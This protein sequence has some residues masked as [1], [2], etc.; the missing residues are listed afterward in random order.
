MFIVR[1]Q[2]F[3]T[4]ANPKSKFPRQFWLGLSLAF[5]VFY[6]WQVLQQAFSSEYV[7]SDDA[8]QHV[9]WMQRFLDPQLFPNDL[10]ADYFQ[11]VAPIGFSTFY[12]FF[13][14]LGIEPLLLSKILPIV[15]GIVATGYC[16][17]LCLEIFP[18]PA[19]GFIASLLFQQNLWMWDD[20]ASATPRAFLHPIFLA[21]LYYFVRKSLVPCLVAIALLGG[22]YPQYVLVASGVIFLSLFSWEKGRI[23]WCGGLRDLR[24]YFSCLTVAFLVILAYALKSSEFAPTI[25]AA[26]AKRL[27]EFL[28]GGRAR[29]FE[30][31]FGRFWLTGERSGI[32][33]TLDPPLLCAG[34]LLPFI[35]GLGRFFQSVRYIKPS[36]HVLRN[37]FISGFFW[38]FTA[39]TLLFKLHLPGRYTHHSL[40]VVLS[41]SAA[42][43]LVVLFDTLLEWV[44]SRS[45]GYQLG[46]VCV[47]LFTFG[48]LFGYPASLSDYPRTNYEQ[49]GNYPELYQFFERQPQE[50]KIASLSVEASNIPLFSHRSI[51][52]GYE[53]AIPYHLGYYDQF[54]ERTFATIE[55]QYTP[56]LDKLKLFIRKYRVNFWVLDDRAFEVDYLKENP[57]IGQYRSDLADIKKILKRKTKEIPALEALTQ[58]C[59]SDRFGNI[60]IVPSS[61]ILKADKAYNF[62]K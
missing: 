33:P 43:A 24:F 47:L 9:F 52:S 23:K 26:E 3:L 44:K 5:A 19:A 61:C 30:E 36:I 1:L 28:P 57:W 18:V 40:R 50:I 39:H 15:L 55:A 48:Y 51:L 31:D 25:T 27:P 32:Q 35:L 11:S 6:G 45:C 8:R 34:L 16:F 56:D 20:L 38:F 2:T 4:A 59:T 41:I 46:S 42:I 21:F 54:R 58:Q 7:A 14:T 62:L 17:A 29:F 13:A 53:Y 60:L 49:I 22:F 10:I 37:L 12:H